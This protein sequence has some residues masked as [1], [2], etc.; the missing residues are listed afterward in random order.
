MDPN[1]T[2]TKL[3]DGL[4]DGHPQ[5]VY[6]ACTD[7]AE[8]IDR[9]GFLPH[10]P[11]VAA[12]T[13]DEPTHQPDR[14]LTGR[15]PECRRVVVVF[16]NHE[17]WPLVECRCGWTGATTQVDARH[18]LDRLM[19]WEYHREPITRDEYMLAVRSTWPPF[20]SHLRIEMDDDWQV[21]TMRCDLTVEV[22][23]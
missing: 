4:R 11:T 13:G 7:L 14:V 23:E 12:A 16:N 19:P 1:A 18:R 21:V 8:W 9:G 5:E 2:L 3:L 15:C 22:D 20:R 6:D 17:S 10:V